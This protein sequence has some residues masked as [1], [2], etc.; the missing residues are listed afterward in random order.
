MKYR[1]AFLLAGLLLAGSVK[2]DVV[3]MGKDSSAESLVPR[4]VVLAQEFCGQVGIK[5]ADC[6]REFLDKKSFLPEGVVREHEE[7]LKARLRILEVGHEKGWLNKEGEFLF[8]ENAGRKWA[9]WEP[10]EASKNDKIKKSQTCDLA[11]D[12]KD[13]AGYRLRKLTIESVCSSFR[14]DAMACW[15]NFE[16]NAGFY[17]HCFDDEASREAQRDM[18]EWAFK[19]G[20]A[21]HVRLLS[22]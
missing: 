15:V 9:I 11:S 2:A 12:S 8:E 5:P 20:Y 6:K 17:W 3:V 13:M 19:N 1:V 4:R 10:T 22:E 21:Y 18:K 7:R 14:I 16:G